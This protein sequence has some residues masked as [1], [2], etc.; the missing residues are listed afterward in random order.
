M[1]KSL[2]TTNI[3]DQKRKSLVEENIKPLQIDSKI[4]NVFSKVPR[5]KFIPHEY[6]DSAYEDNALPIGEG[7][8]ISQPSLVALMTSLLKLSGDMKVLEIGTG[9]GYQTAILSH[10]AKEVYSIERIYSLAEGAK[11]VLKKLE[12]K[13]V[14]IYEG[15]G[16][17]GL[18]KFAPYDAVIVTAGAQE[19]PKSLIDQL[20]EGGR[21][22]IPL[23]ESKNDQKLIVGNKK[24][25]RLETEEVEP[26]RF[27]P[28][29]GKHGWKI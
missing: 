8:T 19:I 25:G 14:C 28:L 16:S 11:K 23:G 9:S 3:F 1:K 24:K 10:L 29:I 22:V 5:H 2:R 6:K 21:I 13:N 4:L 7:Q 15:D 17:L 18:P 20:K 27:V 12:I 26:V